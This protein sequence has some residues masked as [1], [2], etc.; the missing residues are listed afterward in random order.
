M[1]VSQ[2]SLR[3]TSLR[4]DRS[5]SIDISVGGG[6]AAYTSRQSQRAPSSFPNRSYAP[7]GGT[8]GIA[9]PSMFGPGAPINSSRLSLG[10]LS[11]SAGDNKRRLGGGLRYQGDGAAT[12]AMAGSLA[13]SSAA[14]ARYAGDA[15][16][17]MTGALLAG[18]VSGA[19]AR[20]GGVAAGGAT[21]LGDPTRGSLL[22]AGGG[23]S[24]SWV[25][26]GFQGNLRG[27]GTGLDRTVFDSYDRA[28]AGEEAHFG[29]SMGASHGGAQTYRRLGF[30]QGSSMGS[31]SGAGAGAGASHAD[32]RSAPLPSAGVSEAARRLLARVDS[33]TARLRM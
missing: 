17:K 13:G 9:R 21:R 7:V 20:W 32:A 25:R 1:D 22:G 11:A 8:A 19:A 10:D 30:G 14:A 15:G 27:N 6:G 33:S 5:G 23:G 24:S 4:V 3:P 26:S 18:A 12:E 28:A 29:G 31:V 2:G 16:V